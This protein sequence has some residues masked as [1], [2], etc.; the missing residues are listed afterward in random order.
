MKYYLNI[1]RIIFVRRFDCNYFLA[2]G[3]LRHYGINPT[4]FSLILS[5]INAQYATKD[6]GTIKLQINN[7]HRDISVMI[8]MKNMSLHTHYHKCSH[9]SC[10]TLFRCHFGII[11]I[12]TVTITM[13]LD[14]IHSTM[15]TGLLDLESERFAN[16]ST[17]V[18]NIITKLSAILTKMMVY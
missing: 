9:Y 18:E 5:S 6:K 4:D 10:V 16:K 15:Q 17:N 2:I 3:Y 13:P 12:K 11:A 8:S 1:Y 14:S 7:D